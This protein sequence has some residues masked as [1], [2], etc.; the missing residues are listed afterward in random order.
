MTLYQNTDMG[1][2]QFSQEV[3]EEVLKQSLSSFGLGDENLSAVMESAKEGLLN[4]CTNV[5]LIVVKQMME[6]ELNE[7]LGPKGKHNSNR[8]GYRNGY[9]DGSVVLGGCKHT[10][11]RPR[12]RTI[13]GT[14]V[15]LETYEHFNDEDLLSKAVLAQIIYGVSCRNYR[16]TLNGLNS[17]PEVKD[18]SKSSVSRRFIEATSSA[19]GQLMTRPLGDL[20]IVAIYIDGGTDNRKVERYLN[21]TRMISGYKHILGI[22]EGATEMCTDLLTNLLERGLKIDNGILTIIDGSKALSAAIKAVF[23]PLALIQRCQ[24][25]K[26]RNILDYLPEKEQEAMAALIKEAFNDPDPEQGKK[27][28]LAEAASIEKKH[29]GAAASIREGLDE[30]FTVAR[31]GLNVSLLR[32][33]TNTN[34]I[35]SAFSMIRSYSRNVKNWQSGDQA[36][37]WAAA[38]ALLAEERFNRIKGYRELASLRQK[39]RVYLGL[40]TTD[41][42]ATA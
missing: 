40:E 11:R 22:W 4:L 3:V 8:K 15:E 28:L 18:V 25:H 37:R 21:R 9:E 32:T 27:K 26:K 35:E 39:L 34:V 7:K 19:L 6:Q 29:P 14:E 10:I 38:G 30:M 1:A 20:P 41:Q 12:A 24:I 42:V 17:K 33:L 36:L 23:G 5:G 31:L 13:E 16:N 2:P